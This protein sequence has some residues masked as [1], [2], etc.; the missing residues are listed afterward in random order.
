[1]RRTSVTLKN[2]LILANYPPPLSE[3]LLS[4]VVPAVQIGVVGVVVACE[5]I[6]SMLGIIAHP[7]WYFKFMEM[8]L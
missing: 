4:K 2:K 7:F 6:F 3:T 8:H 5:Q 1:M